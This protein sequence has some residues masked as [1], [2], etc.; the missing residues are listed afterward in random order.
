MP[1]RLAGVQARAVTYADVQCVEAHR[2]RS[3]ADELDPMAA[4]RIKWLCAKVALKAWVVSEL[5]NQASK[6]ALKDAEPAAERRLE[7]ASG[8]GSS[9]A[10]TACAPQKLSCTASAS[11]PTADVGVT[12]SPAPANGTD[13]TME[14]PAS[15]VPD[16]ELKGE[17]AAMRAEMRE[18]RAQ[19][20]QM[21]RGMADL[22]HQASSTAN[23]RPL[24]RAQPASP[25]TPSPAVLG[26]LP[27]SAIRSAVRL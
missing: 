19:M 24:Q 22:L 23:S 8:G 14:R 9:S 2:V 12:P 16:N 3:L 10:T 21:G 11:A 18:L 6:E 17:L 25:A 7:S 15:G 1:R 20:Q 27:D 4:R 13:G 26:S 5:R